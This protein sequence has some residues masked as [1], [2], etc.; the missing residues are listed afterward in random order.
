MKLPSY[1]GEKYKVLKKLGSGAAGNVML[2]ENP[3]RQIVAVKILDHSLSDKKAKFIIERFKAEFEIIKNLSHPNINKVYDFG[4]DSNIDRYFFTTE[5]IDGF[6]F[7]S[8]A[9]NVDLETIEDLF[10]QT[11]RALEYLHSHAIVHCDIKSANVLIKKT[12]EGYQVKLIDFGLAAFG[13][14]KIIAGTPSYMAPEII[15]RNQPDIRADLYSLGV[16]IYAAITGFN[17]FKAKDINEILSRQLNLIPEPPSTYNPEIKPSINEIILKLLKKNPSERFISAAHIIRAINLGGKKKYPV[18]TK[19][20]FLGYAPTEGNLIGRKKEL[21]L[22][23]SNIHKIKEGDISTSFCLI[24]EGKSGTGKKRLISELKYYSQLNEIKTIELNASDQTSIQNFSKE[25]SKTQDKLYKPQAILIYNYGQLAT[26]KGLDNISFKIK[27]LINSIQRSQALANIRKVPKTAVI[28]ACNTEETP[29]ILHQLEIPDNKL[30]IITLHN[31]DYKEVEEYIALL[32]GITNPPEDLINSI[33]KYT[34]GNPLFITE[35]IKELINAN[36]LFDKYGRWNRETL[37]DIGLHLERI[38]VPKNLQKLLILKYNNLTKKEQQI[39]NALSILRRPS[40]IQEIAELLKV[41]DITITATALIRAG[42]IKYDMMSGKYSFTSTLLADEIYNNLN[43]DD[44][45]LLH[46]KAADLLAKQ[47]SGKTEILWHRGKVRNSDI[48]LNALKKLTKIYLKNSQ[49][50]EAL[51][52]IELA[53]KRAESESKYYNKMRFHQGE[54]FV[55]VKDYDQA[56]DAYSKLVNSIQ[57]KEKAS[58]HLIELYQKLALVFI[59]CEKLQDAKVAIEKAKEVLKTCNL[60]KLSSIT[61][62]NLLARI[63]FLEGHLDDAIMIY[64]KSRS[65]WS[66]LPETD[67]RTIISND[68]AHVFLEKGEFKEAEEIFNQDIK[69]LKKAD[70]TNELLRTYYALGILKIR[71]KD[72]LNAEKFFKKALGLSK[73]LGDTE[74]LL[75]IYNGMGNLFQT[76]N[77]CIDSIYWYERALDLAARTTE[78]SSASALAINIGLIKSSENKLDEA[79]SYF[80]SAINIFE[81]AKRKTPLDKKYILRAHFELADIFRQKKEFGKAE[82]QIKEAYELAASAEDFKDQL[83]WIKKVDAEITKEQGEYKSTRQIIEELSSLADTDDKK[84]ELIKLQT[85]IDSGVHEKTISGDQLPEILSIFNINSTIKSEGNMANKNYQYLLEIN[86]FLSTETDTSYILKTILKYAIELSAAEAGI[87]ILKDNSKLNI[88]ASANMEVNQ[89]ISEIST[90]I[91]ESSIINDKIIITEDATQDERFNMERSVMSLNL[92]SVMCIPI[93]IAKQALGVI[94]LENRTKIGIFQTVDQELL[95]AFADQAGIAIQNANRYNNIK[96]SE[97]K[98]RSELSNTSVQLEKLT[99]VVNKQSKLLENEYKFANIS[100]QNEKMKKIFDI[101]NKI[102]NTYLSVLI[103]GESGTGKEVIA[104]GIHYNSDRASKPFVAINCGSIP[105]TLIESELFGY[106]AG[107][108]TGANKDKMGLFEAAEGGT[109]FLDEIGELELTLQTKILRVLQER[110]LTRIGD[111][112]PIK[113]DVRVISASNRILENMI[114]K[115]TFREDLYY[116]IAEIK[117][118]LPP[119]RER[120]EDIP[121]LISEFVQNYCKQHKTKDLPKIDSSFLKACLSYAW[122]GNIREL[123]NAVR[124]AAAL[125]ERGKIAINTLPEN[126]VLKS[127]CNQKS[128]STMF[129]PKATGEKGPQIDDKNYYN[130]IKSWK[131][132]EAEIIASAYKSTNLDVKKTAEILDIAVTTMYKKINELNLSDANNSLYSSGFEYVL[133]KTLENYRDDIFKTSWKHFDEHPYQAIK[134]LE[135]SQ[136]F[137]YKVMKKWKN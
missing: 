8:V 125:A 106:K 102:S 104:R 10:V 120:A 122:P 36:L 82:Y 137:F 78:D 14:P 118:D 29:L 121:S 79:L 16:L 69:Y 45:F 58:D 12:K 73:K 22:L 136:G 6:N 39:L 46:E 17:P 2:A 28:I 19:E 109:V 31:L 91:A 107:A 4:F 53:L 70:A 30:Q 60:K 83:F 9:H 77:K 117:I 51:A 25:V 98:L 103:T 110:E 21:E 23:K 56:I 90:H 100:S 64:K 35:I 52:T 42:T 13:S 127:K 34:E 40:S 89:D 67:K 7:L 15:L 1:I 72:H 68:L 87:I 43:I 95:G 88:K 108:F 113:F 33:I 57:T 93:H 55:L 76:Q 115:K 59:K 99:N 94:Y 11:L 85:S 133:G 112:K 116:R 41:D 84:R 71:T 44:K 5:Y 54:A 66:N 135:V 119:L 49:G 48:A 37:E 131:K 96:S 75:R 86:K 129:A 24:I 65:E 92:K 134:A 128:A 20:T 47:D 61:L 81:Q 105:A 130:P 50:F 114:A 32:T 3:E 38:K 126:H 111:T 124:V 101:A 80:K 62:Q 63:E 123:E 132:Y 27:T 26:Q 97:E 74:M 18:E